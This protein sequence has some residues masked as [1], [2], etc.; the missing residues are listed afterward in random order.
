G[1][2]DSEVPPALPFPAAATHSPRKYYAWSTSRLVYFV[3]LSGYFF[4]M[5]LIFIMPVDIAVVPS[6]RPAGLADLPDDLRVVSA[7]RRLA[8]ASQ[9]QQRQQRQSHSAAARLHPPDR[10]CRPDCAHRRLGHRLLD[11]LRLHLVASVAPRSLTPALAGC[12]TRSCS[13]TPCRQ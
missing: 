8:A 6:V 1:G 2:P 3:S 13:R 9:R 12:C 5:L 7:C 11:R 4:S 10:L